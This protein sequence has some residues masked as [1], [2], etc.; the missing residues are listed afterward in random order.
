MGG[1]EHNG[2][3]DFRYQSSISGCGTFPSPLAGLAPC[4]IAG[5]NGLIVILEISR[6]IE[7][8]SGYTYDV[9][10]KLIIELQ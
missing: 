8:S 1:S 9:A 10:S 6:I 4:T 7:E 2:L 5:F 3:E